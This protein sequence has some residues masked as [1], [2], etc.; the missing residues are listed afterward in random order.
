[1]KLDRLLA[2]TMALLNQRRVTAAELSE[3][4]EVSLRTIYR[5]MEAINQAGIPVVSFPGSDGGYEIME[6]YRLDKQ[7]LT[8]EDFVFI[9][10]ALRGF[11]SATD[12]QDIA[13]LL[14]RIGS[15]VPG[16]SVQEESSNLHLNYAPTPNEK[17]KIGPLNAAI[18][19]SRL[20]AFEYWD[21]YGS[22]TKRTIEPMGLY[23]KGYAWYVWG[24]C[25]IRSDFRIF[26]LSRI[27]RLQTLPDTFVRRAM[28]LEQLETRRD[29]EERPV[30]FPAVLRFHP[31]VKTRVRDEFEAGRIEAKPDGFMHVTNSYYSKGHAIRHI[32]SYSS[33]VQVLSPPE[34]IEELRRHL[35]KIAQ[36]YP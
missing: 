1:M 8:L 34:L 5:D 20:A 10:T 35:A 30:P 25:R 7:Y 13:G 21:V 9:C 24:Y 22:E 16:R 12:N 29:S 18:R 33:N 6:G 23:L 3:R 27:S 17:E 4:F 11:Q 28:T 26:R 14:E 2:I 15:L 32:L 36:L 19:E 31:A